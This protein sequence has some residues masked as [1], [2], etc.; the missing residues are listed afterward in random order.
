MACAAGLAAIRA[1]EEGKLIER[2]RQLGSCMLGRLREMQGRHE[3]IADVRGLGLFAVLEMN[4]AGRGV[5]VPPL[6]VRLRRNRG[7]KR[8][9]RGWLGD[10]WG[11][12]RSSF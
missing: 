5:P 2:S 12:R 11:G 1:Y 9:V 3:A 10:P 8:G 7:E 4:D 6:S